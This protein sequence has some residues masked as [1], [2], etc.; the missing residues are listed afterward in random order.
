MDGV[1]VRAFVVDEG[2]AFE[3]PVVEAFEV[4]VDACFAVFAACAG[5][6]ACESGVD[7]GLR[8]VEMRA[9]AFSAPCYEAVGARFYVYVH[10]VALG[11]D[12]FTAFALA[13]Y[14][15]TAFRLDD[16]EGDGIYLMGE[17]VGKAEVLVEHEAHF[18]SRVAVALAVVDKASA[19]GEH[20]CRGN[21]GR[22]RA[23]A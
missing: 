9:C 22:Q 16:V 14:D 7:V 8:N 13:P 17:G 5:E 12:A 19:A 2:G 21:G 4:V 18:V 1:H 3:A 15:A 20:A 6:C 11:F 23:G 10:H